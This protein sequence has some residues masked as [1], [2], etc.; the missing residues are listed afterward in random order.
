MSGLASS[1]RPSGFDHQSQFSCGL[2]NCSTQLNIF[3]A[4]NWSS[5]PS[6]FGA[7]Q[8]S[9]SLWAGCLPLDNYPIIQLT[10]QFLMGSESLKSFGITTYW[11]HKLKSNGVNR[12][13]AFPVRKS[14]LH[15]SAL[16]GPN[17]SRAGHAIIRIA[18]R[19]VSIPDNL[20]SP[21]RR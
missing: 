21:H 20:H 10:L 14:A 15:N 19:S 11:V 2:D 8:S 13:S 18:R 9:K 3:H 1:T 5:D 6:D 7:R 12:L 16:R 4:P 17:S